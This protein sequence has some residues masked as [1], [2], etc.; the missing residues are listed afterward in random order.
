MI[1]HAHDLPRMRHNRL[2]ENR[3]LIHI[4][5]YRQAE[6]ISMGLSIID[7]VDSNTKSSR[8]RQPQTTCPHGPKWSPTNSKVTEG[9]LRWHF[10]VSLGLF[11]WRQRTETYLVVVAGSVGESVTSEC[12]VTG[13]LGD[14]FTQNWY[15]SGI[16]MYA[17]ERIAQTL[18]QGAF[19]PQG[20]RPLPVIQAYRYLPKK[21]ILC[22]LLSRA[23]WPSGNENPAMGFFGGVTRD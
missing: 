5:W 19:F 17:L 4:H 21:L 23:K 10:L 11:Q 2:S 8:P 15:P 12:Q 9:G 13:A 14:F 3:R 7:E 20:A 22:H 16:N 6:N 18:P 1:G